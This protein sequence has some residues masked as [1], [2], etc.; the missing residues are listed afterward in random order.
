MDNADPWIDRIRGHRLES[1][2]T[3]EL[4]PLITREFNVRRARPA[5]PYS[6]AGMFRAYRQFADDLDA[7]GDACKITDYEEARLQT[8]DLIIR[9]LRNSDG[10]TIWFV[11]EASVAIKKDDIEH[12]RQS[13]RAI[14]KMYEQD[15][16]PLVCGYRIPDPLREHAREQ[17]VHVFIVPDNDYPA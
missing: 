11:V 13:A 9:A 4:L 10:A 15:A 3:K 8:T 1:N 16:I 5:W 17:G 2:L 6:L 14:A 7:A 12:A